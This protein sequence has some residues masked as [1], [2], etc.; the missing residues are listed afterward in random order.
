MSPLPRPESTGNAQPGSEQESE[1][2]VLTERSSPQPPGAGE[3]ADSFPG[4]PVSLGEPVFRKRNLSA[5]KG[6]IL[7]LFLKFN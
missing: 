4:L 7:L 1:G 2:T 5:R 6:E 3:P